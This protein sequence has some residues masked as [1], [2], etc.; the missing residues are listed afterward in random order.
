MVFCFTQASKETI[1]N[2]ERTIFPHDEMKKNKVTLQDIADAAGISQMTVSRAIRGHP[3]VREDLQKKIADL[4]LSMGYVPNRS[5]KELGSQRTSMSV[6][7]VLPYLG[8]TIFAEILES[9]ES[10][11]SSYG[12]RILLC[13][14]YNNLI[15]EFHDISALL[16]RQVDGIIW[17]PLHLKDSIPAA[18]IIKRQRCPLVF[19]DRIIPDWKAD[20]VLTDDFNGA[21]E[22][23]RHF[24]SEGYTKIAYVGAAQNS[25]VESKRRAGYMEGMREKLL[26]IRDEWILRGK[27]DFSAG[28]QAAADLLKCREI[29]EAALCFCDTLSIGVEMGLLEHGI[30]I[31]GTMA[32]AGFSGTRE[33]EITKVPITGIFQDAVVLGKTSAEFLLKR[34]IN[35]KVRLIPEIKVLETKLVTRESSLKGKIST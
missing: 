3:G 9:I 35:P 15:K 33:M 13:C 28:K 32:L 26:P 17:A 30:S 12:Y 5:L 18:K 27:T 31:P 19:V 14:T 29:P 6:G 16:E 25:Y 34:M 4:A 21:L 20:G 2:M 23:T 11:L 7:V 22:L 24:I 1:I 8:N 10:V